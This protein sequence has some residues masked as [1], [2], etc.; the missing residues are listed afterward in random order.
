MTR[1]IEIPDIDYWLQRYIAGES[2]AK[3]AGEC[4]VNIK[5]LLRYARER[6]IPLRG[7]RQTIPNLSMLVDRYINGQSEKS[8]CQEFGFSRS[9]FRRRLIENGIT[10]RSGSDS[11]R[12]R[13]QR[14]TPEQRIQMTS[15]AHTA[16]RGK[17]RSTEDL[18]S[19]ALGKELAR[20]HSTPVEDSLAL[21][22]NQCGFMV[23]QQKAIGLYNVDIALHT[24][25]IAI[26]IFGGR[27]HASGF[28]AA[29]FH[30]RVKYILNSVWH[31]LIIWIDA[32]YHPL[33]AECD[34]AI[35]SF[36]EELSLNPS[37]SREY[38][39]ILGNGKLAPISK[40]Y[41]NTPA[42]IERLRSTS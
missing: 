38:R 7:R 42:D 16:M 41:F 13:W 19:R 21:R 14:A 15:N 24:P 29:R 40:T 32:K 31:V 5:V 23:T 34:K 3:L 26:E 2:L 28:H 8:I 1:K 30:E 27:F 25:P 22:L 33:S 36:S 20:S 18:K 10:P 17:K 37:S 39:V 6:N 9:V 35:I 11:M 4:G 12:L